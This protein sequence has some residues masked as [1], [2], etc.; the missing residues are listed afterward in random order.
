MEC[1]WVDINEYSRNFSVSI[2]TIRR[3]IKKGKLDIRKEKGKYLIKADT[4]KWN[5]QGA[6]V[7]ENEEFKRKI[8]LLQQ[9]IYELKMLVNIYEKRGPSAIGNG[10]PTIPR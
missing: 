9:E 5:D 1:Q 2:S 8:K 7:L 10:P 3:H 4:R 6:L